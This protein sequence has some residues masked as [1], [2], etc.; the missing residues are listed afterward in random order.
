MSNKLK[1][2]VDAIINIMKEEGIS[3]LNIRRDTFWDPD[4][5]KA[6]HGRDT[7]RISLDWEEGLGPK[8]DKQ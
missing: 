4:T 6:D 2:L 3:F 5:K 1:K 7:F 8:E